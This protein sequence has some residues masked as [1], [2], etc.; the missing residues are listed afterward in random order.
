MTR[1]SRVRNEFGEMRFCSSPAI[2][3]RQ[4]GRLVDVYSRWTEKAGLFTFVLAQI[5]QKQTSATI[6][7]VKRHVNLILCDATQLHVE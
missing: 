2:K 6:C 1:G 7:N 3:Y 5:G 4:V